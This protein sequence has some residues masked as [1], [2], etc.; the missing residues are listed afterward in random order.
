MRRRLALEQKSV[1]QGVKVAF[2]SI[3]LHLRQDNIC[4]SVRNSHLKHLFAKRSVRVTPV[5]QPNEIDLRSW[6]EFVLCEVKHHQEPL[7]LVQ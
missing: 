5:P 3:V 1:V 6:N 7:V 4:V 2:L